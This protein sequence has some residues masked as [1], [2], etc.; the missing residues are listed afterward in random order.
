MLF[1]FSMPNYY[2]GA[3]VEMVSG[4]WT[5]KGLVGNMISS[6]YGKSNKG[7]VIT[8][9]DDYANNEYS[10]FG[11]A[12]QH[13]YQAGSKTN[14]VEA[15]AFYTRG[16]WSLFGSNL[17]N[18]TMTALTPD[19]VNGFGVA[20]EDDGTGTNTWVANASGTGV[21]RSALSLGLNYTHS[22]NVSFK[23]E[24]P[25]DRASGATFLQQDGSYRRSNNTFGLSTLVSF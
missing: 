2:A 22:T 25:N 14:M 1:N 15:D 16:D 18:E 19:G 5:V 11:F 4:K 21:N 8:Y 17:A 12:G 3:G 9:R 13:G 7:Q 6:R 20:M 23:A 10:G 24:V